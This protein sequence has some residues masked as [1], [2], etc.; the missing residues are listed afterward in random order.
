MDACCATVLLRS[1]IVMYY[2]DSD[3][4]S[5]HRSRLISGIH[6][7]LY[8]SS[9]H[10]TTNLTSIKLESMLLHTQKSRVNA[11]V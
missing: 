4:Y 9:D 5:I 3:N 2:Q 10:S 1:R 8:C 6:F 7:L 11:N